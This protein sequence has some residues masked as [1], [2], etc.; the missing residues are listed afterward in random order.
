L[1][2]LIIFGICFRSSWKAI[3]ASGFPRE[4]LLLALEDSKVKREQKQSIRT[5]KKK[6]EAGLFLMRIPSV[7]S[8]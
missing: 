8:R 4:E 1:A 5:I 3:G 6:R 7:F 2:F